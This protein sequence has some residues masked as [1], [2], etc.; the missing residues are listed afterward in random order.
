MA[1]YKMTETVVLPNDT[2]ELMN[3]EEKPI[4]FKIRKGLV[5]DRTR[6]KILQVR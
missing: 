1:H 6:H 3:I 4:D 2:T 5:D